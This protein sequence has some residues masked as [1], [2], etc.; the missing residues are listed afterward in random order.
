MLLIK[1]FFSAPYAINSG[2]GLPLR[3]GAKADIA[4][5]VTARCKANSLSPL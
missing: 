5:A 2:D 3:G 4:V 1:V